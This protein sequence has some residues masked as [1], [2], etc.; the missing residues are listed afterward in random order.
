MEINDKEIRATI[1][2]VIREKVATRYS[3][4]VVDQM[5]KQFA[6]EDS[7][8]ADLERFVRETLKF[9]QN[10]K[11]FEKTIKDEFRHKVAKSLVSKLEGTVEKAVERIRQNEILRSELI[12]AIEKIIKKNI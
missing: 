2:E 7:F 10:D 6:S 8:R 4:D 12:L 11:L 9:L 1:L 3:Y 5:V